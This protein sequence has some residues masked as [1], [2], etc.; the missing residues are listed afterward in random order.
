MAERPLLRRANPADAESIARLYEQEAQIQERLGGYA[1]APDF[2]WTAWVATRLADA[3]HVFFVA[4]AEGA[5]IGYLHARLRAGPKTRAPRGRIIG[6]IKRILK[7][8]QVTRASPAQCADWAIIESLFISPDFRRLGIGTE[9]VDL[10]RE[11][12]ARLGASNIE[13]SVV[14]ANPPAV[15]FWSRL[16]FGDFRLHMVCRLPSGANPKVNGIS[17]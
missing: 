16:G 3:D 11:A 7:P 4:Q 2:D 9:L 14:A 15:A 8:H 12:L 17:R 13:I 6:T 5:V 10:A 1:L